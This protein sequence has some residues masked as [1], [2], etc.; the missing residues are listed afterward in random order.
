MFTRLPLL[1]DDTQ[2][3]IADL[4]QKIA[5]RREGVEASRPVA[6]ELQNIRQHAGSA[7]PRVEGPGGSRAF[8][9]RFPDDPHTRDFSAALQSIP[10]ATAL[11]R[12]S[13]LPKPSMETSP[14]AARRHAKTT[15]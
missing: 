14:L 12:G 5:L 8:I 4:A 15:R 10:V 2:A 3:K 11:N 6:D 7:R 13:S 9:Q 1:D